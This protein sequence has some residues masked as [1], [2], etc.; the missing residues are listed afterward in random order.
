MAQAYNNPTITPMETP[1]KF[2]VTLN[3][4]SP[5]K[6]PVNTQIS[7]NEDWGKQAKLIPHGNNLVLECT[8]N[9]SINKFQ[10]GIAGGYMI[11]VNFN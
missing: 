9:H 11:T 7:I 3:N 1:H 6:F 10:M 4:V 5:G 8:L 2:V